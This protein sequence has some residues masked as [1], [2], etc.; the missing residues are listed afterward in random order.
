MKYILWIGLAVCFLYGFYWREMF[1]D[2]FFIFQ[3][4]S[5]FLLSLHVYLRDRDKVVCYLWACYSFN[6]LVD[7]LI[8]IPTQVDINEKIFIVLTAAIWVVRNIW[9]DARQDN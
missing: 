3:A 4:I 9:K 6:N 2:G 1:E 8:G 7:E 5:F